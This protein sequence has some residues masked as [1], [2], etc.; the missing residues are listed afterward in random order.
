MGRF[1]HIQR[2]ETPGQTPAADGTG[3]DGTGAQGTG[4][5]ARGAAQFLRQADAAAAR[6]AL[7][8]ALRLYGRALEEDRSLAPAWLGQVRVLLDMGQPEEAATWMEQTA[9]VIGE[10]PGLLALR[11]LSAVRRGALD[12]ARQWSDRAMRDGQ[13]DPEVWLARAAVVY[14]SGN[15]AVAR[16]NLDKA[17]E[18]APGAHSARRCA[19]VALDLGDL[20]VARTWL[21]RA[22]RE[23]P[24][25][26]LIC[27]RLGVYHERVGDLDQARH[28]LQR[29]LQLDPRLELAQ[30]ALADLDRRSPLARLGARLKHWMGT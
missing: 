8:S 18:R 29:A 17:H 1:D 19:E 3:A 11:A 24:E 12:E 9:R 5:E 6:G 30:V 26:P 16:I 28:L 27:L 14:A 23:D 10:V 2:Q 21:Q 22:E 13:D 4:V 15:G 7:Q 25:N 20:G